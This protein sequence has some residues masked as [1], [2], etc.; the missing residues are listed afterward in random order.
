MKCVAMQL[1]Q[2]YSGSHSVE[3]MRKC[4]MST[5]DRSL[6]YDIAL[7]AAMFPCLFMLCF[8]LMSSEL[9]WNDARKPSR[10]ICRL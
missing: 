7:T 4:I 5:A 10:P 8:M 9:K 1:A 2:L 3:K 6:I